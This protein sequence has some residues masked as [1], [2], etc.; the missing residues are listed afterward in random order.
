MPPKVNIT[1]KRGWKLIN[2]QEVINLKNTELID[3]KLMPTKNALSSF[4]RNNENCKL[5][6]FRFDRKIFKMN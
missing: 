4:I 5:N 3:K 2:D 6:C 1:R